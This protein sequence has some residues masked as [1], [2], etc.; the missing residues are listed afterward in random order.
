MD[1]I[2]AEL[3]LISTLRELYLQNNELT[4]TIPVALTALTALQTLDL[5][6]NPLDA[7][8]LAGFATMPSLKELRMKDCGV[9]GEIPAE[10]GSLPVMEILDL[11]DNGS[12][13]QSSLPFTPDSQSPFLREM[14]LSNNQITG[15]IPAGLANFLALGKC[16]VYEMIIFVYLMYDVHS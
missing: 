13:F 9:T 3:S 11:S 4:G 8:V 15:G 6:F 12:N 14:Y 5:S 16:P 7:Q 10:F 2:P 1:V